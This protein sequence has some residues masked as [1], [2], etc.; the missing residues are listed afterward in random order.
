MI[1]IIKN[2]L[3]GNDEGE[4]SCNAH[5][6]RFDQ[7]LTRNGFDELALASFFGSIIPV[8]VSINN[9]SRFDS[10]FNHPAT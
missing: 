5:N 4:L 1:S 10:T 3:K 6:I 8:N 9:L 2:N 7:S